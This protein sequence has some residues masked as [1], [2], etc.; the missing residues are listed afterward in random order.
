MA[1][2]TQGRFSQE[3]TDSLSKNSRTE[4]RSIHSDIGSPQC[5]NHAQ[6]GCS[7]EKREEL[8]H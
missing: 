8:I 6:R 7:R 3:R 5:M 4:S 1:T 2:F